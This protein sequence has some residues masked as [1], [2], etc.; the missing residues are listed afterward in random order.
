MIEGSVAGTPFRFFTRLHLTEL[1]GMRASTLMQ[2]AKL[3]R[4]VPG[5]SIYHHTHRFLQQHQYLS[6][7]PPNDFAYW[8]TEI[9]GERELGEQLASLD[10]VGFSNIRSLRDAIETTISRYLI[11][12]PMARLKFVRHNDAFHFIKSV[13]FVLP[14]AFQAE[15]LAEF[16]EALRKVTVDSLYYHIFEARLRLEK[17]TNDFSVWIEG[18][19]KNR[20]LAERIAGMDPYTMTLEHLRST[21]LR[22]IEE[23][24]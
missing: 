22:M 18:T 4:T 13:S 12:H 23:A 9:L 8:I 19:L 1:T 6:P 2:L 17:P 10:T 15:T 5:S 24:L 11:R 20:R 16:G 21:I 7:E 14:T 3:I